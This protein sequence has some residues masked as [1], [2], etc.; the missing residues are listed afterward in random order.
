MAENEMQKSIWGQ[1]TG[2]L[3]NLP[4]GSHTCRY[5]KLWNTDY[6]QFHRVDGQILNKNLIPDKKPWPTVITNTNQRKQRSGSLWCLKAGGHSSVV[7]CVLQY[8]VLP[9]ILHAETGAQW[10][11]SL[12]GSHSWSLFQNTKL[13]G[14]AWTTQEHFR[15]ATQWA[16][17]KTT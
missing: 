17:L 10:V 15:S 7:H 3:C 8:A 1:R 16:C 4:E 2:Y 13:S 11:C 5:L 9:S 14:T 6:N 12:S